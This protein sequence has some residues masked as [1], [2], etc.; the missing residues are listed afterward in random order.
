MERSALTLQPL[1]EFFKSLNNGDYRLFDRSLFPEL[2]VLTGDQGGRSILE[3]V[4]W[5]AVP[6]DPDEFFEVD[7][8][9]DLEALERLT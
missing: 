9:A 3:T 4:A 1:F 2:I 8:S 5:E 6:T 7:D